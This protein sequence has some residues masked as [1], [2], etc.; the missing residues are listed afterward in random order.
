MAGDGSDLGASFSQK[1][2]SSLTEAMQD[3][4]LR[5]SVNRLPKLTP[6]RRSKLTPF[7]RAREPSTEGPARAAEPTRRSAAE[8]AGVAVGGL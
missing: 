4:I 7:V 8:R 1:S 5:Q 6:Y 2:P 3:A